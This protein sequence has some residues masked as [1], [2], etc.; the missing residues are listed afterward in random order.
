MSILITN[1]DGISSEGL[2]ALE[3]AASSLGKTITVAPEKEQSATGHRFTLHKP[4]RAQEVGADR[5]KVS[6]SPADCA[7]MGINHFATSDLALVVSGINRGPNLGNDVY[8]SGTAAGAR[9]GCRSPTSS[10]YST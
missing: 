6:G 3:A 2:R 8:Y 4:L 5:W 9:E 10:R 7:Y 1:D